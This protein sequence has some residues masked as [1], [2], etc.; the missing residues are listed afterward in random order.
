MMHVVYA[1]IG[2]L[3]YIW[4]KLD[5]MN[6]E[7]PKNITKPQ[8]FMMFI[9]KD[10]FKILMAISSIPLQI[11]FVSLLQNSKPEAF[12]FDWM[13]D[14]APRIVYA[15]DLL[16]PPFTF[17]SSYLI[18]KGKTKAEKFIDEKLK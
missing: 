4:L 7:T 10:I 14:F 11:L 1:T 13:R 6:E 2:L 16:Y 15:Q 3:V 9:N 8:L 17:F 12:L 18:L 5:T